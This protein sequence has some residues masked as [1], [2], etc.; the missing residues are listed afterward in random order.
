L[1]SNALIDLTLDST[2]AATGAFLARPPDTAQLNELVSMARD[3]LDALARPSSVRP[4]PTAAVTRQARY[5]DRRDP[6]RLIS[7]ATLDRYAP[8][9]FLQPDP[10][11]GGKALPEQSE[12]EWNANDSISDDG[13]SV[14]LTLQ[15]S[16][17]T[18]G[19][20]AA[21][22]AD[23]ATIGSTVTGASGARSPGHG[24]SPI[25]ATR[26][27]PPT[28]SSLGQTTWSCTYGR[29]TPNSDTP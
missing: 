14:A 1:S 15:L 10:E 26:P 22:N 8:G 21:F 6:C 18:D 2:A 11:T 17:G 29:A 25:S 16:R 3:T 19:A 7:Q 27:S 9:A 12:C 5:A 4:P 13:T 24:R 28:R 20:L 23:A